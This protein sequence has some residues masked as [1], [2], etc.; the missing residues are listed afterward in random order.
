MGF[1]P[2]EMAAVALGAMFRD[3]ITAAFCWPFKMAWRGAKSLI[4]K[5]PRDGA[6][7][8]CG[9]STTTNIAKLDNLLPD[10]THRVRPIDQ[11]PL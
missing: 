3:Q 1:G 8:E 4:G 2:M 11:G 5:K 6:S 7:A 10:L 9:A